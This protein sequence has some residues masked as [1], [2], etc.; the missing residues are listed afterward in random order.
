M[1]SR[2]LA[3]AVPIFERVAVASPVTVSAPSADGVVEH[4]VTGISVQRVIEGATGDRVVARAP[5]STFCVAVGVIVSV[6]TA[7]MTFSIL[8][9]RVLNGFGALPAPHLSRSDIDEQIIGLA[10]IGRR[11]G[12]LPRR[13]AYRAEPRRGR[14]FRCRRRERLGPESPMSVSAPVPA[15]YVL[16]AGNSREPDAVPSARL[17]VTGLAAGVPSSSTYQ[18]HQRGWHSPPPH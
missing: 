12:G 18:C 2:T 17:T 10:G 5:L 9:Q 3:A 15:R 1:T 11:I 13:S 7:P 16:D 8:R 4:V 14:R 6:A